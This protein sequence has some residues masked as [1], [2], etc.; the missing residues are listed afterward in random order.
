MKAIAKEL[1]EMSPL[2]QIAICIPAYRESCLLKNTLLN[3][4]LYQLSP[5]TTPLDPE[6]FEINILLNSPHRDS[7]QDILT[8]EVIEDFRS[9]YPQYH[10]NIAEMV[11]NFPD[12]VVM[13]LIF[14][15]IADA[16]ILR[17]LARNISQE[18]KS[19]LII[20]T[21]GADV[22]ALNPLLI[23]RTLALFSD[24]KILAHR[25]ESRLPPELLKAFP[26]LHVMQTF[27]IFFLRQYR[28]NQTTNGP[29]SYTAEVYAAVDGFD[30][31]IKLGEEVD[32]AQK[33]FHYCE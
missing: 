10:I 16:T 21:A 24:K 25:G 7:V 26:L 13:G 9:E 1:G 5:D 14:K 30:P 22:E 2:C 8:M 17:N 33:I 20:R 3:Y 28:G 29:F 11:Y 23:S 4:T 18:K 31:D 32:L 19:R 27:A 15:D 12:K 6:L